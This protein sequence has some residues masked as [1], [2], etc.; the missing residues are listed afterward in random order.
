MVF[1]DKD[2]ILIFKNLYQLKWYKGRVSEWISKQIVDK[3]SI[4]SL[5]KYFVYWGFQQ[6]VSATNAQKHFATFPAGASAP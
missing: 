4:N 2:K 5:L 6:H 1:S 3:N